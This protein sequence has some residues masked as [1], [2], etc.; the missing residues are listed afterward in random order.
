MANLIKRAEEI[1][2]ERHKF[3]RDTLNLAAQQKK[4]ITYIDAMT[5]FY[6]LK[7][8]QILEAIEEAENPKIIH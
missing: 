2:K 7:I 8:G 4:D 3:I 5:R 1:E 6:D